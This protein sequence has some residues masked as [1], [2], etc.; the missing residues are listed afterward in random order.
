VISSV[1]DSEALYAKLEWAEEH[2]YELDARWRTDEE[3]SHPVSHEDDSKTGER[4]YRLAHA[5]DINKEFPLRIGDIIHNLRSALDQV[6]YRLAHKGSGGLIGFSKQLYFPIGSSL[7]DFT[8]RLATAYEFKSDSG[9]MV[10]RLRPEAVKAIK[11]FQP[12]DGGTRGALWALH[13]LDIIDKHHLLLT[14]ASMGTQHTMSRTEIARI[15]AKFLG[16]NVHYPPEIEASAFMTSSNIIAPFPLKAGDP[17]ARIPKTE[18]N[19]DMK[20]RFEIAFVE[21]PLV[22]GKQVVTA[23]WGFAGF[24]REIITEFNTEGLF[25]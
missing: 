20:F 2:I 5:W 1:K 8:K 21:P 15:K 7:A 14:A 19:E 9:E 25:D 4:I 12:Y 3:H 10:Q 13:R 22:R 11:R 17:I 24:V 16:A 23:L 18:V 6:A